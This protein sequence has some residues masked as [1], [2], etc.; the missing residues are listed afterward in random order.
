MIIIFI[1]IEIK[2]KFNLINASHLKHDIT[3]T[4]IMSLF[5]IIHFYL[6]ISLNALKFLRYNPWVSAVPEE[7]QRTFVPRHERQFGRLDGS[8]N[9][10]IFTTLNIFSTNLVIES[11]ITGDWTY[12][13]GSIYLRLPVY[14]HL[15][16]IFK[17]LLMII[18]DIL[19][20]FFI[21]RKSPSQINFFS[22]KS[23]YMTAYIFYRI[24]H[25]LN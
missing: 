16:N 8:H 20:V 14:L 22:L 17:L 19:S 15:L 25:L 7:V 5:K 10:R 23:V 4:N 3:T 18:D 13:L 24:F 6:D 1:F 11:T 2:Q 21:K 9:W 12:D